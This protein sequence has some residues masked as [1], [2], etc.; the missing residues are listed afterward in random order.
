MPICTPLK[1][2]LADL[3]HTGIGV[4]T[5]AF[6]LNIGL[7]AS[8]AKKKFGSAIEVTLFKYPEELRQA[9]VSGP[10]RI[11][12]LSNYT[13]NSRL[14]YHFAG[15][16]K[17]IDKRILT[18]FGGTNYPFDP[19]NQEEF[20][21]ARPHVDLHIFYEGEVAFSGVIERVLS[22]D[23]RGLFSSPLAGCQFLQ[24]DT[25]T[26][27]SGPPVPRIQDLDAIPSPY[28]TGLLDGFFDGKLTPL[29]ETARG[30]PF[31][32]NFCNAGNG[33]FT[34]VNLF[35]DDY[36]RD[37]WEYV[38]Q[39]ASQVGV[40]HMTLADNNFGMIPRDSRTAELLYRLQERY[41]WPVSVTAWTGKNSKERVIEVTRLLKDTL[42]INMAV[43]SMDP[44][45]LKNIERSNIKLDHYTAIAEEL[46]TQGRPQMAEVIVPLPGETWGSHL[47]G[48]R[49]LLDSNVS[50]V[51]VHTLQMLH[52]TPYKDSAAYRREHGFVCKFR[53]VP[54]DFGLYDGRPLF[55]TEEV[56]VA[57][58]RFSL[59][60]YVESRK[61]LFV[62]DL[63]YNGQLCEALKRYIL[64]RGLKN[65]D[66]IETLYRQI[67]H[68]PP[69]VLAIF[70]SF[71][72]ETQ[73]ELWDSEEE[74]AQF[75]SEPSHYQKLVSG[76]MGGNVLFKHKA[77]M[78]STVAQEWMDTILG[79]SERFLC[80]DAAGQESE[81]IRLE[82]QEIRKFILCLMTGAFE[83][84]EE[85][86][87]LRVHF[88]FDLPAWLT[89]TSVVGLSS[90]RSRSPIALDFA[91][92]QEQLA[93]K[94][95]AV[96]RYGKHLPG[97][98]KLIQRLAG[99]HRLMRKVSYGKSDVSCHNELKPV[100][101]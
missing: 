46:N 17:S 29:L 67:P 86:R 9:L 19:E 23:A 35:S 93:I 20:L 80:Q 64:S 53:V 30:C 43:Q 71:E 51:I 65:S 4:A 50:H 95:D 32:C 85:R 15:L 42:S 75:Y 57:T 89:Q 28:A 10:P 63:A 2:Y 92:S 22:V 87:N 76:E 96:T 24:R 47:E 97:M 62:M 48:V 101:E 18:V 68:Y 72:A 82:L 77:L 70:K 21:R 98:I 78:M 66:W 14:S 41:G 79:I 81:T 56:A 11:L 58:H 73:S 74:L 49:H 94:R 26:L 7:I 16:A 38:A 60:D 84:G 25:G 1:I 31:T 52:G 45:V 69:G 39:R 99:V 91:F 5:E 61:L 3:T 40:G 83:F 6:P 37:E 12:G 88:Q 55:D 36:V 100:L 54:L 90:Y 44:L 33:Y 34:R 8:Y 13:W 27:C 59:Q